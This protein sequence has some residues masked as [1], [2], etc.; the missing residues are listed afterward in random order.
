MTQWPGIT[1]HGLCKIYP[2]KVK[3]YKDNE[4][5]KCLNVARGFEIVLTKEE[6]TWLATT[7]GIN[8]LE[9]RAFLVSVDIRLLALSLWMRGENWRNNSCSYTALGQRLK[10][11]WDIKTFQLPEVG[12]GVAMMRENETFV[13]FLARKY[14][15]AKARMNVK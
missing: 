6:T 7:G 11:S 9:L 2:F 1:V 15:M 4:R 8:S 12:E 14:P 13:Q 3:N 10:E 5:N